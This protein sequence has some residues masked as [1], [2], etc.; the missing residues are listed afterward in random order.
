MNTVA[1]MGGSRPAPLSDISRGERTRVSLL[2]L[3][4]YREFADYWGEA[5]EF[6]VC[7]IFW[8]RARYDAHATYRHQGES[9]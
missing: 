5:A 2:F 8:K 7:R 3:A 1:W 4:Q 6:A 9:K